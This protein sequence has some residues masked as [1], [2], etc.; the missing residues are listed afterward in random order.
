MREMWAVIKLYESR[1]FHVCDLQ[2]DNEFECIR[3]DIRP[4]ELNIVPADSH[5]GEV[6]SSIRMLKERLQACVHGLPFKRLP[7]TMVTQMVT[8]AVRCLNQFPWKC[9]V[10]KTM[11]PLSIVTG[12]SLPD[13]SNMRI[14]FGSYAQVFDERTPTCNTPR[15]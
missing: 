9:G 13:N 5:V 6:E 11:S 15:A 7:K 8:D 1:G 10:S 2:A 4:I 14:E 12:A 3:H